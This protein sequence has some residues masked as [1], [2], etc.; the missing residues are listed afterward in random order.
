M[1]ICSQRYGPCLSFRSTSGVP[2]RKC[3]LF[4]RVKFSCDRAFQVLQCLQQ[5]VKIHFSSSSSIDGPGWF[6]ASGSLAPFLELP[7][8]CLQHSFG[9][10]S[11]M[12]ASAPLSQ[13]HYIQQEGTRGWRKAWHHPPPPW[14]TL[15]GSC[16]YQS[17]CI[18]WPKP[19]HSDTPNWGRYG[20]R[21]FI[22]GSY[23]PS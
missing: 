10:R 22:S 9:I 13:L 4:V 12:A 5:D 16:I 21:V 3:S 14:R 18:V 8:Y 2:E 6:L 11:K 1:T 20:N 17:V 23:L 7:L 15:A 19:C